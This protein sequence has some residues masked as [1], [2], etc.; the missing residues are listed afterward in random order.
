[1][2][3]IKSG[4]VLGFDIFFYCKMCLKFVDAFVGPEKEFDNVIFTICDD[5]IFYDPRQTSVK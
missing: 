2:I 5:C 3:P 1:M 4:L